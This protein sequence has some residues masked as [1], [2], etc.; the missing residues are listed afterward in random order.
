MHARKKQDEVRKRSPKHVKSDFRI[1]VITADEFALETQALAANDLYQFDVK[2]I[3]DTLVGV[4]KWLDDN[5]GL[6]RWRRTSVGNRVF[7]AQG[8]SERARRKFVTQMVKDYVAGQVVLGRLELELPEVYED[9]IR[10]KTFRESELEAECVTNTSI[11]GEF[12][13]ATLKG[14]KLQLGAI[15]GIGPFAVEVLA[16]EA[17]SDWLI[18]CPLE[19]E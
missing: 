11:P 17:V 9:V 3:P 18:R 16:R 8:K 19:F 1:S 15:S 7:I 14:Y 2:A 5:K 12:F 4:T 6:E 10:R 13:N